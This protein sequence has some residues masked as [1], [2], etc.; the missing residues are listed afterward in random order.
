MPDIDFSLPYDGKLESL[1]EIFAMN[2]LNSNKVHEVYFVGP[3]EYAFSQTIAP[4]TTL[5]ATIEA[6]KRIRAEGIQTDLLMNTACEGTEWYEP[7]VMKAKMEYISILHG[8]TRYG[9]HHC[10]QSCVYRR[11]SEEFSRN[12]DLRFR[13]ELRG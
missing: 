9:G 12:R 2:R 6:I 5:D 7:D 1:P 8:K 10:F 11:N 13:Y 3:Q 4:N